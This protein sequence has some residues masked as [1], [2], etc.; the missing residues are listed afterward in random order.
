MYK[1]QVLSPIVDEF[2]EE[3]EGKVKVVK[4][5][6]DDCEESAVKYGIRNIPTLLFFK[7]GQVVDRSVGVIPKERIVSMAESLLK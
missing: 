3:Y 2:A 4:C 7:D 1:R 6:I 5:N